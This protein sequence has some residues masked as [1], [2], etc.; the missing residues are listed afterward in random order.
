M[1]TTRAFSIIG[2]KNSGKTSLLV[3]LASEFRQQGKR[4]MTLKHGSHPAQLDQPGKD[5]YRH[6]HE[7]GAERVMIEAPGQRVLIER[8]ENESDPISLIQ[9][10]FLDA[11]IVLVEG[12]KKSPLPKVEVYRT[13]VHD[14]PVYDAD[15]DNA[16]NWIAVLTDSDE[17]RASCP[18]FR[19]R[20]TM[21]LVAL[22]NLAWER[23]KKISE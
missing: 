16:K 8:A 23:A 13:A 7:G 10:F 11:D 21:W 17:F 14:D 12:F 9:R 22:T 5:T 19:F 2:K 20:D 15:A 18:V 1:A 3:A 6:Y 4:V